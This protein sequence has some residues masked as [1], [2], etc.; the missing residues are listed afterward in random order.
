M[1]K[2]LKKD[3]KIYKKNNGQTMVKQWSINGQT[4]V[5]Q[6]STNGQTVV[7]QWSNNGQPMV[8]QWST[9]GQ[10]MVNHNPKFKSIPNSNQSHHQT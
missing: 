4:V 8:N 3:K 10:P 7:N 2:A 5:N 6:W 1:R 9:N